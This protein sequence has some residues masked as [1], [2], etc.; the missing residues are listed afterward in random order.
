MSRLASFKKNWY[1]PEAIPI[2]VVVGAAVGGCAWYLTRLARGPDIV[3]NRHGNP[4]PWNK[5]EPGTNTKMMQVN[6]KLD[7]EYKREQW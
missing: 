2:I 7:K 3:W 5:V 1:A 6:S 4:E